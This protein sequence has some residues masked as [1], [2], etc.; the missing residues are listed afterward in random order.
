MGNWQAQRIKSNSLTVRGW[1][2]FTVKHVWGDPNCLKWR[3]V[4]FLSKV[5][6]HFNWARQ[7]VVTSRRF[8]WALLHIYFAD[9]LNWNGITFPLIQ[10]SL[11]AF[12][13]IL[14]C[15]AAGNGVCLFELAAKR[16][17]Q[18][19][20]NAFSR[21]TI[22]NKRY[23]QRAKTSIHG[24]RAGETAFFKRLLPPLKFYTIIDRRVFNCLCGLSLICID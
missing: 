20:W 21:R 11:T 6:I 5:T 2:Y 22:S 17:T 12:V 15:W 9:K 23:C 7:T 4:D 8:Y 3:P 14:V 1:T 24:K 16:R 10:F 18:T 13:Q 19:C